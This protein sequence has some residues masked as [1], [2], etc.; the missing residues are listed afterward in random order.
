M[1]YRHP[2]KDL[3]P[4]SRVIAY[5]RDSGGDKQ[6]L[7]TNDQRNEIKAYC[8]R[9]GLVLIDIF[10]D[11]ARSGTSTVKRDEFE[12]MVDLCRKGQFTDGVLVWNFARFARNVNDA[13]YYKTD[14]RRRGIIVHSIT[15]EIPE[16]PY[17]QLIEV[18]IDTTNEEKSR[19]TSRDAKRGL[20]QRTLAG[21]VPGGGTP[22]RGYKAI[23]EI[24]SSHRDG[25]PRIGTKLEVDPET[26]PLVTMAFQLRAQGKSLNEIMKAPCGSL[27]KTKSGWSKFW[28]N[29]SYLGI[30]KC[31]DIERPNSHPALVDI[32]T[33]EAVQKLRE[34]IYKRSAGN[35]LHPRRYNS[36]S[37]LS[38]IAVCAICGT[39]VIRE[40]SGAKSTKTGKWI[41]YLCGKKRNSGNWHA[42]EGKQVQAAKA[43]AAIISAVLNSIL[44]KDFAN[45]LI[46][47]VRAQ[48]SDDSEI[49]RQEEATRLALVS[50]EKAIGRLLDTI[51]STDSVTAK[52]RLKEREQERARL[53]FEIMAI[54]SRR[55]AA[56]LEITPE[57]ME[58]MLSIWRGDIEEARD[59]N[60]VRG[61]QRLIRQFVSKIEL[62]Y[63]TARLWYNY[64]IEAFTENNTIFTVKNSTARD[65]T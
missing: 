40:V 51:E 64:P 37:L 25:S 27:Y 8:K 32:E 50:C 16:G 1:S 38:G 9:H 11:M 4:G 43:D 61:L 35:V 3:P 63:G 6:E 26:G 30:L 19:Q 28:I 60:D 7:S 55:K 13:M 22:P 24:I 59:Q 15:D 20:A 39:P 5:L 57:A 10:E 54:E 29:K 58:F 48:M 33:W 46:N 18:M 45:E 41:A 23:R 12:R 42:C 47:Q 31:G 36:P 53:Q 21:Y 44:T 14:L 65:R 56:Q 34:K 2:P 49:Q 52:S 62:N 17:S